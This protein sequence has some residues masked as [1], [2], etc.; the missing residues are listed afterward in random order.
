MIAD[1]IVVLSVLLSLAFVVAWLVFP[2]LRAWLER[3]KY[4]FQEHLQRYDREH[5]SAA[6]SR[7]K[8]SS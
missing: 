4:G 2:N 7:R 3:P 5:S 8:P 6:N 1:L